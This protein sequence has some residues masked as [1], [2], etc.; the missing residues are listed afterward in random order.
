ML[1]H[2]DILTVYNM[3]WYEIQLGLSARCWWT[4]DYFYLFAT[5]VLQRAFLNVYVCARVLEFL[6][7]S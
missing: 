3:P 5:I 7:G 1:I 6:S 4:V 2:K